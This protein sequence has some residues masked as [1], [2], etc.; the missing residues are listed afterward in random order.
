MIGAGLL[1]QALTLLWAHPLAFVAFLA[2]G[3]PLTMAG[4]ALY[5][6]GLILAPKR[7]DAG[8]SNGVRVEGAASA[9]R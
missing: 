6:F 9:L 5:L 8:N 1:L 7:A 4:I 3:C 2:V